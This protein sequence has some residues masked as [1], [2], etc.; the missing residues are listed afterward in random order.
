MVIEWAGFCIAPYSKMWWFSTDLCARKVYIG[1]WRFLRM[2]DFV[3]ASRNVRGGSLFLPTKPV[4]DKCNG[5]KDVDILPQL[6]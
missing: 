1:D 5:S 6:M 4:I 3:V 2:S